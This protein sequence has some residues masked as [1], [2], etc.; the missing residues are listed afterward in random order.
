MGHNAPTPDGRGTKMAVKWVM[1]WVTTG[2][3]FLEKAAGVHRVPSE[4]DRKLT[5]FQTVVD[6]RQK[7][8]Q[9]VQARQVDLGIRQAG[10]Q[11]EKLVAQAEGPGSAAVHRLPAS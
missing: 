11:E 2:P 5:I 6:G 9:L 7:R 8:S 10:P 1:P 4:E 3:A